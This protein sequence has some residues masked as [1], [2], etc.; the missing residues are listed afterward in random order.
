MC[1]GIRARR[2][3]PWDRI[4]RK[5]KESWLGKVTF[6]ELLIPAFTQIKDNLAI[7]RFRMVP[8]TQNVQQPGHQ[9]RGT[10]F[11]M[12]VMMLMV[13]VTVTVVVTAVRTCFGLLCLRTCVT[14]GQGIVQQY[15]RIQAQKEES[16]YFTQGFQAV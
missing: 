9:T 5:Q 3:E 8:S 4:F 1:I 16:R 6:V 13:G 11:S 14:V 7:I 12:V 10:F 15:Q 2:K